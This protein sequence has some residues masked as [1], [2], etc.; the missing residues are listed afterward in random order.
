MHFRSWILGVKGVAVSQMLT[1]R[2]GQAWPQGHR[3]TLPLC[4]YPH[5]PPPPQMA[6]PWASGA[7][8]KEPIPFPSHW[9]SLSQGSRLRAASA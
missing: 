1:E 9:A 3:L 6:F 7:V 4:F 5:T 8:E 2:S